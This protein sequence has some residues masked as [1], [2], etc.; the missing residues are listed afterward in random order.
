MGPICPR[1]LLFE[2]TQWG[3]LRPHARPDSLL[4]SGEGE[5]HQRAP[6]RTQGT[7]SG[8]GQA[9]APAREGRH[10]PTAPGA[11]PLSPGIGPTPH[12]GDRGSE[13]HQKRACRRGTAAH[14]LGDAV[15]VRHP[16]IPEGLCWDGRTHKRCVPLAI[17]VGYAPSRSKLR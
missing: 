12:T 10:R 7:R 15:T 5:R 17:L 2:I 13:G 1:L 8:T 3:E 16:R 6:L 14:F 4:T 11:R 9:A